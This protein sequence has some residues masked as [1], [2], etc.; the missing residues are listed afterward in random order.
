MLVNI[1][2]HQEK[3]E[4]QI[5]N[6]LKGKVRGSQESSQI[7]NISFKESLQVFIYDLPKMRELYEFYVIY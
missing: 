2:N 6:G 7:S 5:R 1:R 4:L 3:P